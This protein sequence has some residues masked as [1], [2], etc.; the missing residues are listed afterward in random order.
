MAPPKPGSKAEQ[1]VAWI[2]ENLLDPL[3]GQIDG[4]AHKAARA[5]AS[6]DAEIDAAPDEVK[7]P[8]LS[9]PGLRKAASDPGPVRQNEKP[10]P[11]NRKDGVSLIKERK[12]RP[13]QP[14]RLK[15]KP[16]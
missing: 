8:D 5:L 4:S 2:R 1:I 7:L 6:P 10:K 12:L 11:E 16:Q 14:S 9:L 13:K 3:F 15:L